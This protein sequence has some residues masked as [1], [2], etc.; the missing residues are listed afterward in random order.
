M[1]FSLEGT[2]VHLQLGYLPGGFPGRGV[3]DS[4]GNNDNNVRERQK[5]LSSDSN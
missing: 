1:F 5:K 2:H 3:A 4:H